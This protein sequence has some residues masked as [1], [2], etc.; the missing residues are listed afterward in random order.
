MDA[1]TAL[2]VIAALLV[3]AALAGMLLARRSGRVRRTGSAQPIDP[4]DFGGGPFGTA[5]T[6]I[7]F[8]TV[9][10][11]R[12]PSVRRLI[13]Q[14]VESRAGVEFIHVDVTDRPELSSRYRL[15]QTPTVLILDGSGAP[16]S[17]LAGAFSRETLHGGIESTIGNAA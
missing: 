17:R 5:G 14:A 8:S 12:C 11:S 10:C 15:T 7:Q 2:G 3:I 1:T 16:R 9:Y 13:S 4:A 6:I